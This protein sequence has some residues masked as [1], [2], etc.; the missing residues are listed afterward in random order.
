M[1]ELVLLLVAV[2][3]TAAPRRAVWIDT[4]PSVA[5]GG[6]EIDD[7]IALLDAFA[8]PELD[9]RGVSIVY[10]N[11]DLP[12]A[13]RIGR[14]L[15]ELFGPKGLPVFIGA[16]GAKDLGRESEASHALAK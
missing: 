9:I 3:M 10:G 4:D 2:T 16:A 1:R 5:R 7:G 15:V 14:E 12:A 11:A 13:S 8:S 6:H